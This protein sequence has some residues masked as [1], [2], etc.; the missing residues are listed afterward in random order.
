MEGIL[1]GSES[2]L[3]YMYRQS[4]LRM[5][6]GIRGILEGHLKE[7]LRFVLMASGGE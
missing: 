2:Y 4:F 3:V 5:V 6:D 1:L 7:Y